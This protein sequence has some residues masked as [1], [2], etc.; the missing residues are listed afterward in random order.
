MSNLE[1]Q[2]ISAQTTDNLTGI[3]I[4][5]VPYLY[6]LRVYQALGLERHHAQ[7]VISRLT[8]GIHYRKFSKEEI[9]QLSE[10]GN[11]VFPV[12]HRAKSFVF[13]TSEGLNRAIM[14]I[15]TCEMDDEK[16]A[17]AID[18][19]KDHMASIYTRYQSGEV[20]SK[21]DEFPA[22]TGEVSHPEYA[23]V[24]IVLED[25]MAIS[26]IMIGEG[27]EPGIAKAMAFSVTEDICH[28]GDALTPWKNLIETDPL[29]QEPATLNPTDIGIALGGI[30]PIEVNKILVKFGY[31]RKIGKEWTPTTSG[32]LY[33]RFVPQEIKHDRGVVRYMQL[34]WLP[35]IV[36][37]LRSTLY[38]QKQG[39]TGLFAGEVVG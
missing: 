20:L 18:A 32:K 21:A 5:G 15:R 38:Y 27:V 17:A 19:K 22:L 12:D 11:T 28:C 3:I 23:P 16:I 26:R 31:Q 34:R 25:Q 36:E 24:A 33:A 8:E 4:D 35:S 9:L 30:S 10:T 13:L 14:E 37:K 2:V 7:K 29:I 6:W 1:I 39:Q